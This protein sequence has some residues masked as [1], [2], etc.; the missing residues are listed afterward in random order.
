MIQQQVLILLCRTLITAKRCLI[1][2]FAQRCTANMHFKIK[3][4]TERSVLLLFHCRQSFQL[5]RGNQSIN[6]FI[7]AFATCQD[8]VQ[9]IKC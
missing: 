8:I 3:E 2:S 7:Q 9:F 5:V 1:C 6:H 4:P